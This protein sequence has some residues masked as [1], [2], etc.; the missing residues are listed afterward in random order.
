THKKAKKAAH[1]AWE[2]QATGTQILVRPSEATVPAADST[3]VV[4]NDTAAATTPA[5]KKPKPVAAHE[6]VTSG[7]PLPTTTIVPTPAA[8]N[9]A[10]GLVRLSV[11][12]AGVAANA[13]GDP[14]LQV[15]LGIAGGQPAD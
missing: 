1:H 2:V 15:K 8:E 13:N 7:G 10:A 11:R 12:S 6:V 4:P 5:K 9:S 14:E 3:P